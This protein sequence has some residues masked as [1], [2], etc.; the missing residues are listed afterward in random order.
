MSD[1]KADNMKKTKIIALLLVVIMTMAAFA[2]CAKL[3]TAMEYKGEK[4]TFNMYSYWMSK[5]KTAY[6]LTIPNW[7]ES[8]CK[9]INNYINH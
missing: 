9:C 7:D 6:S 8:L 2:S 1:K 3:E 4:I 5:I